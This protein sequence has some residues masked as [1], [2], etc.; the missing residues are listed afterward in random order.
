MSDDEF[1][2]VPDEERGWTLGKIFWAMMLV[3]N[4]GAGLLTAG[5]IIMALSQTAS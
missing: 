4:I 5:H 2:F 3:I 1:V